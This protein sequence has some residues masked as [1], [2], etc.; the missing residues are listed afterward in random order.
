[1]PGTTGGLRNDPTARL[2]EVARRRP[3]W[4]GWIGLLKVVRR[5][6][7]D[8]PS[9]VT[10]EPAHT[11]GS[12]SRRD[13]VLHNRTLGVDARRAEGLIQDLAFTAATMEEGRLLGGL[14]LSRP[15]SLE[16]IA[17][18][19]T[20]DTHMIELLATQQELNAAA[21][22][23]LAHLAA[24]PLLQACTQQLQSLLPQHWSESYCPICAAWPILA[25]RRGLDRSRRL[26]CGRC[27]TDWEVE[28]LYCIY[29]GERDH[30]KLGSLSPD[31]SGELLKVETCETCQGYLKS[32]ASLQGFQPLELLLQDL[33]TVELDLVALQRGYHRPQKP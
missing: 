16:L 9:V 17:A 32:V 18:A 2:A 15:H 33:E 30:R 12:E 3:E 31:E 28:W 26:R 4:Q 1:M 10:L 11:P 24:L 25:E 5:A 27:A 7:D 22:E 29:C 19:I 23:S 20:H 14:R 8:A 13:P 6:M 21:L